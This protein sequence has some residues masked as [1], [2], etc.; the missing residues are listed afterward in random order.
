MEQVTTSVD[1]L[2]IETPSLDPSSSELQ[3]LLPDVNSLD[4]EVKLRA[5]RAI[6]SLV[7]QPD[8][9]SI[10][11]IN[12]IN[13]TESV[14]NICEIALDTCCDV[15][16]TREASWLLS[17]LASVSGDD[18]LPLF[19]SNYLNTIVSLLKNTDPQV[20]E[21][22]FL[23]L[24]NVVGEPK[25]RRE[26]LKVDYEGIVCKVFEIVKHN[27]PKLNG[28]V[29][30]CVWF[31][32]NFVRSPFDMNFESIIDTTIAI[33]KFIFYNNTNFTPQIINDNTWIFAFLTEDED[34]V[35][36]YI[37]E[38]LML[39]MIELLNSDVTTTRK[40]AL[41]T[42]GN[43]IACTSQFT[44]SIANH[45]LMHYIK[46]CVMKETPKERKEAL[47]VL[48]N[49]VAETSEPLID[50]LF[51]YDLATRVIKILKENDCVECFFVIANAF[52]NGTLKQLMELAKLGGLTA[53]CRFLDSSRWDLV[54][55]CL[56]A[57]TVILEV[58]MS[59]TTG[60]SA[61]IFQI[62][63]EKNGA[64]EKMTHM[65]EDEEW[66]ECHSMI[67]GIFD[68]INRNETKI[69]NC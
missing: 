13:Q 47:W 21:Q 51:E 11:C 44:E 46:K 57:I 42:I 30:H 1:Q 15:Q 9:Y 12:I 62:M 36:V 59:I 4:P 24:G 61:S 5:V 3:H 26:L 54:V 33:A 56:E 65:L 55:G 45:D 37:D 64:F 67:E 27:D 43:T 63:L 18:V 32:S 6:R 39:A 14:N 60:G 25:S 38:E 41:I 16:L 7:S 31:L 48:S 69:E 29:S 50:V 66:V 19:K 23:A 49:I 53:L 2:S 40:A 20:L 52:T 68:M 17:N 58:S 34:V 8:E 10:H 28:V 35:E 22:A